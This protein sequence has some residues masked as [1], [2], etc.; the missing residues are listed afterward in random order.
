[1]DIC[2]NKIKIA[3]FDDEIKPF[4]YTELDEKIKSILNDVSSEIFSMIWSIAQD[5]LGFPQLDTLNRRTVQQFTSRDE[6]VREVIFDDTFLKSAPD[7]ITNLIKAQINQ[8][9]LTNTS[10]KYVKTAFSDAN[11]YEI[12]E[13]YQ[14][15]AS[16]KELAQYD[17]IVMDMMMNDQLSY[18]GLAEYLGSISSENDDKMP[19]IILISHKPDLDD[20]RILFREKSKIPSLGFSILGKRSVTDPTFGVDGVKLIWEQLYTQKEIALRT[21]KTFVT[22]ENAFTNAVSSLKSALWSLDASALQQIYTNA[23]L[24]NDPL[25][26]HFHELLSKYYIWNVEN[27]KYVQECLTDLSK[28]FDNL[29]NNY[30]HSYSDNTQT[31]IDEL[32]NRHFWTGFTPT[33]QEISTLNNSAVSKIINRILP[34]GLLLVRH[35]DFSSS[36]RILLHL[37]QQC[38]LNR[39]DIFR[40]KTSLLFVS[41]EIKNKKIKLSDNESKIEVPL[42]LKGKDYYLYLNK[43][44]LISIPSYLAVKYLRKGT[45]LPSL[46]LRSE[47]CRELKNEILNHSSRYAQLRLTQIIEHDAIAALIVR[48]DNDEI[49]SILYNNGDGKTINLKINSYANGKKPDYSLINAENTLLSIWLKNKSSEENIDLGITEAEISKLLSSPLKGNAPNPLNNFS[50]KIVNNIQGQKSDLDMNNL[51]QNENIGKNKARLLLI[52]C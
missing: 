51:L 36:P 26:E 50:V 9:E 52:V 31:I 42:F 15:P 49:K 46:R 14:R 12:E 41:G 8:R 18:E 19:I 1:M 27:N 47:I 30:C 11:R 45:W 16:P 5:K 17:L 43:N 37:T 24:D 44:S 21:R 2:T 23:K 32:T 29:Q 20:Y 40:K 33:E 38:D 35:S 48:N 6:L 28:S 3:I 34:F 4:G 25:D 39:Q 22:L 10:L 13:H 7:N